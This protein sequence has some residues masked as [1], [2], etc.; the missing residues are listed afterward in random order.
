MPFSKLATQVPV[1]LRE[2]PSRDSQFEFHPPSP[3]QVVRR[4]RKQRKNGSAVEANGVQYSVRFLI[5]STE[6]TYCDV[7]TLGRS[8][9]RRFGS[10]VWQSAESL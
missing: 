10:C 9:G 7:R 3:A 2:V 4:Q 6:T 5:V 8:R 1:L